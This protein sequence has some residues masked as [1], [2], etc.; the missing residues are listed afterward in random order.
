M[1]TVEGT[2][3]PALIAVALAATAVEVRGT[4]QRN[5]ISGEPCTVVVAFVSVDT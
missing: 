3:A 1:S 2:Q 4:S 5:S